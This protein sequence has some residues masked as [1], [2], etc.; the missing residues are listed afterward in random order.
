MYSDNA[1]FPKPVRKKAVTAREIALEE[2]LNQLEQAFVA[3]KTNSSW[4]VPFN[5]DIK[6]PN[7][8]L[9]GKLNI[10]LS[11][12]TDLEAEV[13]EAQSL[14]F[15]AK[16][17]FMSPEALE[18][19]RTTSVMFRYTLRGHGFHNQ[20]KLDLA[21][22]CMEKSVEYFAEALANSSVINVRAIL[23]MAMLHLSKYN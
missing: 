4:F 18:E 14:E 23:G 20:G 21:I 3:S 10:R 19:A 7:D 22:K 1:S 6:E 15:L 17:S 11:E 2:R 9:N 16:H 12:G 8:I 5:F 13:A